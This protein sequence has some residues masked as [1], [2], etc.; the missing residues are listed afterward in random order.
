MTAIPPR[1]TVRVAVQSSRRLLRDTLAMSLAAQPDIAVVGKV[2]E[3]ADLSTLCELN[4]PDIVILD[5]GPRLTEYAVLTDNL[6]QDFPGLQVIEIYQD[7]S[8]RE[9]TLACRAR[10]TSLIP[11][12]DGL[13][14]VL[15][16]LRR[17]GGPR[18]SSGQG[19]LADRELKLLMLASSGHSAAE[20]AGVFGISPLTV[21]NLKRRLYA[22]LGVNSSAQAVSRAAS[23]G[24]LDQ[25]AD[26][27][28]RKP[29]ELTG[30]E[31]DIL[32]SVA[33]GYSV[34]QT[35]RALEVSPKTVENIQT[36]L[37]RKL[38]V[39]NR[40][41]AVAAAEALGLLPER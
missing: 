1:G 17:G 37:F 36:G 25:R 21:E 24:L 10:G 16:E 28:P 34:R 20:I 11:E 3:P 5:A 19:S 39:R 6:L 31:S 35:A 14:G 7:A 26:K 33:R 13:A 9:L 4:R 30:R 40:A 8:E 41:Q 29:P 23:L 27:A 2:A 38:E 32:R 12:S 22:K 15:A 18:A